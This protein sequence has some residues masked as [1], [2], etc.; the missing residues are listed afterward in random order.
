M[1]NQNILLICL[2]CISVFLVSGCLEN[3]LTSEGFNSGDDEQVEPIDI[4]VE[5]LI[6]KEVDGKH[7]YFF[8]IRNYDTETFEGSVEISLI[9]Q[10]G[11][12][13]GKDT[14]ST[15]S[16]IEPDTGKSVYIDIYTAPKAIHGVKGV[17]T[18]E[19][20]VRKEYIVNEGSED[21]S[22][23]FEVFLGF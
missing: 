11:L 12:K 22:K 14:F 18:Y 15:K 20:I 2:V 3:P 23:E 5:S 1:K 17:L 21:I 16:P 7:R 4:R 10:E 9:T 6:V 8:D 13:V 19:Y